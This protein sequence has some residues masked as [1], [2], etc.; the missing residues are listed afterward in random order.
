MGK[1]V[2]IV[3]VVVIA[4]MTTITLN[5]QRRAASLP[6][7]INQSTVE[8]DAKNLGAYAL[9]YAVNQLTSKQVISDT[10]QTPNISVLNGWIDT[11]KYD[12]NTRMDT[13][14]ITAIVSW[15]NAG[16]ENKIHVSKADLQIASSATGNMNVIKETAVGHWTFEEGTG[17]KTYDLTANNNDGDFVRN[18]QWVEGYKGTGIEFN[19]S[20]NLIKIPDSPSLDLS[21]AGTISCWVYLNNYNRYGELLDKGNKKNAWKYTAYS[22]HFNNWNSKIASFTIH[23]EYS[24]LTQTLKTSD[25]ELKK[26]HNITATFDSSYLKI[27]LDGELSS[28][29]ENKTGVLRNSPGA[30][31]IGGRCE[32]SPYYSLDGKVDEVVIWNRALSVNEVKS[33][34]EGDKIGHTGIF[35][36]NEGSGTE[37]TDYMGNVGVI[38]NVWNQTWIDG[39]INNS[40]T[41]D[42]IDDY[43]ISSYSG[44]VRE[45]PFSISA[46]LKPNSVQNIRRA[47]FGLNRTTG[48]FG[49]HFGVYIN[50]QGK[51]VVRACY[52][53]YE[54]EEA[55]GT[56]K[57]DKDKWNFVTTVFDSCD[58]KLYVNNNHEATINEYVRLPYF[59][60]FSLG[61]WSDIDPVEFGNY[62]GEI[63]DVRIWDGILDENIID[64]LVNNEH[65]VGFWNFEK[66]AEFLVIRDNSIY[67]NDGSIVGFSSSRRK[68]HY[69]EKHSYAIK[70]DGRDDK[71]VIPHSTSLDLSQEISVSLWVLNYHPTGRD[72]IL[73]TKSLDSGNDRSWEM[74]INEMEKLY[75]KVS[76]NEHDLDKEYLT[77][78]AF[79]DSV[80]YHL[81]F[82][83]EDNDL[84]LYVDGEPYL[85]IDKIK[86][87]MVNH[88]KKND[89]AI[90]IGSANDESRFYNGVLDDVKIWSKVLSD[91]EI[92]SQFNL[93]QTLN[94]WKL[95]ET[96]GSYAND[97]SRQSREGE[98]INF[99]PWVEGQ[100]GTAL[101]FDGIDDV[102]SVPTDSTLDLCEAGTVACWVNVHKYSKNAGFIHKGDI[103]NPLDEAYTLQFWGPKGHFCFSFVTSNRGRK[104]VNSK[105]KLNL[106]QWYHV[107][108]TFDE[109][110]VKLYIDGVVVDSLA[111]NS[112]KIRKSEGNLN[113]GSQYRMPNPSKYFLDGILD[114]VLVI[115]QAL[116][117]EE[118]LQLMENVMPDTLCATSSSNSGITTQR[119]YKLM[120]WKE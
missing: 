98:L 100:F 105:Q 27:Y 51:P 67:G 74:G 8:Y 120:K 113:I 55:I 70:F 114:E 16:G 77:N 58:I 90:T 54:N 91:E 40:L 49:Q 73:I 48:S 22:L 104:T 64:D 94:H 93:P 53:S 84:K 12:F 80:W 50:E 9:Q 103:R 31:I 95:D 46:W 107:A 37:I 25:L 24:S 69:E 92:R 1:M 7:I 41:F 66:D 34:F 52:K 112:S 14:S 88:F 102:V 76:D 118:I 17:T 97:Y 65:C 57:I 99:P 115:K 33:I 106:N 109:S 110:I 19:G 62:S 15:Q 13:A 71:V 30:L 11:L 81:A 119:E 45:Y 21:V 39:K 59:Y 108:G 38:E 3:F 86:D 43:V 26:W 44:L 2:L 23:G 63:D 29:A 116:S 10:I 42:G 4:I 83:F 96:E 20:D 47:V 56:T 89:Q 87:E 72:K 36:L 68:S 35:S 32:E 75:V 18:P 5:V 78:I 6:S 111:N 101:D 61:Q 117:Q 82:T 85:D 60:N 28:V 79:A